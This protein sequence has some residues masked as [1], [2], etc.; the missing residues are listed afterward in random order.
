MTSTALEEAQSRVMPKEDLT[1]YAGQWVALREGHVVA[2]E[3]DP[4]AL[5]ERADVLPSDDL[6]PVPAST[7]ATLMIA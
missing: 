6:M 7:H 2:A 4:V 3:L 5:R 1:P